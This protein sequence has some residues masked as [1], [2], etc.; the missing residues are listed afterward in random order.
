MK[1]GREKRRARGNVDLVHVSFAGADAATRLDCQRR[2]AEQYLVSGHIEPGLE[3]LQAVLS[4]V[5]VG[6]P[7]SPARALRFPS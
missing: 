5:G 6:L 2:A 7:K 4:E 1:A 3:A